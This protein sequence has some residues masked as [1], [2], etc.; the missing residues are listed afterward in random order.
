MGF[1][2]FFKRDISEEEF[3]EQQK[4][5][6]GLEKTRTGFFQSIVNT[7]TNAQI[8]DD[9]YDQLEEQLILADVGPACAVRLVDELHDEV[10]E[11]HLKTGQ[12]ALDALRGIICQRLI[13][14][15]DGGLTTAWKAGLEL[16]TGR[17]VGFVDSDDWID[18]DMYERMLTLAEQEDADVTVCG[19]VFDFEDPKI[20]K[21]NEISNFKKEVYGRA[22][23]E[24]LFPTLINDGYFFGRTLQPARVTKLFRR[25]LLQ[26]NVQFCDDKVAVGEDLQ[27]TFPV[28]LDTKKLC[29]VQNFYPYHYWINN[30]SITG[31]YD[32]SYI[33][34]VK[35]L[36]SR[37]QAISDAKGVYDF[38]AQIRNDFLGLAVLAVKNEI[39]RNYKAGRRNV[40]ANVKRICEDVMVRDAM[41]KHTMD[42]LSASIKLYLWLMRTGHYNL[43]YWLVLGFFKVN[44]YL[45]REY[46]RQ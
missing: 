17:Y 29:V 37:L 22:D 16:A 19:L 38:T 32:S 21:R 4:V 28:L 1:F 30:K 46:K 33:E 45:G 15:A 5:K 39:Y 31:Q 36:S 40:V 7:L 43:C 25:S 35:L 8:D 14:A 34:K 18:A 24:A 12:E 26:A 41:E 2:N 44:Y 11:K 13:P 20:P 23:L 42:K 6:R 27:I 3:Q 10:K 9:L